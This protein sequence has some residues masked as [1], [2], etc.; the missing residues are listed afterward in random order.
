MEYVRLGKTG[1]KVSRIC[2]GTMSFGNQEGWMIELDEA[3][4]IVKRA[5]DLGINFF[6]TANVYSGG[7]SEEIL[8]ATLTGNR[9]N[10]VIA[11]KVFFP[12]GKG[13]N[14]AGLSRYHMLREIER[15]LKRLRTDH[16][17][18]Y[19]I[20]RWDYSTPVEETLLALDHM[21]QT[22]KTM[23]IGASSMFAWQLMKA[24]STSDAM[25]TARF[26]SMQDHYNLC[27]REDEREMIPLCR[28]QGIALLPWSPLARGFLSGKYQRRKEPSGVRYRTDR[29][30]KER[31]FR[32][33]DFDVVER[34]V[35]VAKEKDVQPSQVALA[36]LL[37][38]GVTAPILGATKV[39]HV[40][41]AVEAIS[42]KLSKDDVLRLEEPYKAHPIMGHN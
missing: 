18:L 34:T 3:A 21:V 13:P 9:E 11:T 15:S 41:D 2:L 36:W 38:K 19:Q 40:E 20:H 33:E 37:S 5:V 42:I 23:Y 35:Q 1:L 17:D 4:K 27:Y 26:V 8:G 25:K 22:G 6:D 14:D 39:Q 28:D 16:V 10:V 30:M 31:F 32:P 24:L 12:I 29:Y 7:R